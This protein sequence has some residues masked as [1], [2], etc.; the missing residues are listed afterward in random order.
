MCINHCLFFFFSN[1]INQ[2]SSQLSKPTKSEMPWKISIPHACKF[3]I[4][5]IILKSIS[6]IKVNRKLS[7]ELGNETMKNIGGITQ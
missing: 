6:K 4:K 7:N 2:P 1:E 3:D 5:I